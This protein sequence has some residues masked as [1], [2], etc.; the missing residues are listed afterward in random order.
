MSSA[1]SAAAAAAAPTLPYGDYLAEDPACAYQPGQ[2]HGQLIELPP[3]QTFGLEVRYELQWDEAA[4][5]R[6][7]AIPSFARGMVAKAGG[8][9]RAGGRPDAHHP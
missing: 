8:S 6:L 9:I 5:A 2:Y 3:E 1:R 4:Q 7:Q